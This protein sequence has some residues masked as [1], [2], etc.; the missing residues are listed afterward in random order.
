MKTRE[1]E[2][3]WAAGLFDGEGTATICRGRPRLGLR[4]TDEATVRRFAEAVGHGKVY[5]PY[6]NDAQTKRD[7]YVRKP[8]FYWVAEVEVGRAVVDLLR[9]FLS[10]FRIIQIRSV[11]P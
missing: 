2:I 3:A 7:G 9:P 8:F 10:E 11:M 4:M 5:G 1:N 6:E